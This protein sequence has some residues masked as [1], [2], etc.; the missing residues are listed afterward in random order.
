MEKNNVTNANNENE[1]TPVTP[2][3]PVIPVTPVTPVVPVATATPVTHVSQGNI[4]A[5]KVVYFL[6]GILEVLFAFRLAFKI[7]GAN[8]QS[9]FVNFIYSVTNL[10]LAPFEG[11]FRSAVTQGIETEAVLEPFLIIAMLVYAAIAW[12]IVK[13][14]E[15]S[16]KHQE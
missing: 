3:T 13:L 7:L 14:I 1:V 15:I 2:V 5:R 12:G 11:I 16:S 10:F 6:L 9:I 8:P 4:K